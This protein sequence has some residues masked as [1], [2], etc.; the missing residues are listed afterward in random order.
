[1][2]YELIKKTCQQA[3]ASRFVQPMPEDVNERVPT[4]RDQW[5]DV[6]VIDFMKTFQVPVVKEILFKDQLR[7]SAVVLHSLRI[8]VLQCVVCF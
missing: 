6:I 5:V 7:V 4:P 8:E 2:G 3:K 1:M